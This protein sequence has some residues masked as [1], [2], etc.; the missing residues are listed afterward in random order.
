MQFFDDMFGEGRV[1][2]G[3]LNPETGEFRGA[4][5]DLR[6]ERAR[7][8]AGIEAAQGKHNL[9]YR[10]NEPAPRDQQ[11]GKKG[12]IVRA[13]VRVIRGVAVDIDPPKDVESQP[14]GLAAW[15][16]RR[17]EEL[18]PLIEGPYG[19]TV[20]VGSG[21][22]YQLLW[23]FQMGLPATP[24]TIAAVEALSRSLAR[25]YG[26]DAIHDVTHLLRI[27]FTVN[28]PDARKQARGRKPAVSWA[29]FAD[30]AKR[31]TLEELQAGVPAVPDEEAAGPTPAPPF[32]TDLAWAVAGRPEDLP[33]DL[34]DR[35]ATA[36]A[37]GVNLNRLLSIDPANIADRSVHDMAVAHACC[38]ARV[39][40][41]SEAAAILTAH[42]PGKYEDKEEGGG[43]SRADKYLTDTVNKAFDKN[44]A[45]LTPI[46]DEDATTGT[47]SSETSAEAF[48]E[49][50]DIFND[51]DP[52]AASTALVDTLPGP[53][54]AHVRT[55]AA[56]MGTSEDF[57]AATAVAVLA[58][59]IGGALRLRVH[60]HDADFEVTA[61]IAIVLVG[62]PGRKKS[63]LVKALMKALRKINAELHARSAAQWAEWRAKYC[64]AKGTPKPKAPPPPPWRQI[65]VDNATVEK[66]I[67]IIADNPEGLLLDP[68]ELMAFLGI[69]DAYKRNGGGDRGLLLR[70]LDGGAASLE[71]KSGST[72][73]AGAP[74][75][76]IAT[77]Q[78]DK[79]RTLTRDLGSDGF[80]QRLIFIVD[81]GV[82]REGIDAPTDPGAAA[83]YERAV[84]GMFDI[85]RIAG[86]TV[87][88]SS[89][90]RT[91]LTATWRRIRALQA[92]PGASAAWEGHVSKWEGF[93]YRI[94]LTF[95]ALDTWAVLDSVPAGPGVPVTAE[96]ARRASRFALA[97]VGHALR[98]YGEYYEPAEHNAEAREVAGYLLTRPDKT[99][100]T[101]REIEK[102]RRPL[103]GNRRL[104]LAAMG[105]LERFGWLS[106]AERAAEG[107]ARWAVNPRIHE[108]FAER[109]ARE[110]LHRSQQQA[111]ISAALSARRGLNDDL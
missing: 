102:A 25:L 55:L 54:A 35:L 4:T 93:L 80:L 5:A 62:R 101:P 110:K 56:R 98:F 69:M 83:E 32:D 48:G 82:E 47:T 89:E 87:Y 33:A 31:Y 111:R 8:H 24:E 27:P 84:R 109:A 106:V 90:A 30:P 45:L 91:I 103:Q 16:R 61:P 58:A 1:S 17:L 18:A 67:A 3:A 40:D 59:A 66:L 68:D 37:G 44:K 10:M 9:Y 23:I 76:M 46:E 15:Q 41:R 28:L 108:R 12:A 57:A 75:G 36:R 2:F 60:E 72:H 29:A 97:L 14:G 79:I 99:S 6:T 95:H 39:F 65:T 49:P 105:E 81:D 22:G 20:I 26:G 94:A 7:I 73:A 78:P 107:P 86:G 63:P 92:L 19:P 88:L 11:Q 96:T 42:F 53:S 104:T 13:D 100:F 77:T 52:A 71:R 38:D 70:I 21:G 85:R 51:D 34:A 74:T 43:R 64:T 50:V